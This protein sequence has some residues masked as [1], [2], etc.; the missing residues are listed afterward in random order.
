MFVDS[1][2]HILSGLDDGA[3]SL[4]DAVLMARIAI[5]S[6]I[7][8]IIATP[9]HGNGMY[10]NASHRIRTGVE[11]LN[12]ELR[13]LDL[14]VQILPG[15]EIAW[16]SSLLEELDENQLVPLN[17]TGY[18][19]LELPDHEVPKRLEDFLYELQLRGLT[20]VI[21]HPE[22]NS[23]IIDRPDTAERLV[24]QG[25]VL[26]LAAGSVI[27]RFGA[28][29]RRTSYKLC[30]KGLVHLIA[31]DGHNNR[32]RCIASLIEAY[33]LLERKF[34]IA[35]VDAYRYNARCLIHNEDMLRQAPYDKKRW[36]QTW[37]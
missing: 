1:H 13:R 3:Q 27:G 26:Q 37:R 19:L 14:A 2:C 11:M 18:L 12:A 17:D 29:A 15:Q 6:G 16:S 25:A 9:H 30:A 24:E 10:V 36:Y 20:T 33:R 21:A 8:T 4:E 28:K 22:R 32:T 31:S 5:Q 7:D 34:G 35:L 23:A